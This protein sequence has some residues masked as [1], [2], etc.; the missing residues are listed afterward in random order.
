MTDIVFSVVVTNE[1][2]SCD[3]DLTIIIY[4]INQWNSRQVKLQLKGQNWLSLVY[5]LLHSILIS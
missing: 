2:Y 1:F 4:L 3:S 5:F